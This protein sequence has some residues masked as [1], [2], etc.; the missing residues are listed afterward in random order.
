MAPHALSSMSR[1]LLKLAMR[2]ELEGGLRKEGFLLHALLGGAL[3]HGGVNALGRASHRSS[4]VADV[5]AHRAF[6][7]GAGGAG[8]APGAKRGLKLLLGPESMLQ[9]EAAEAAGRHFY[10][11]DP[12]ARGAAMRA[13]AIGVGALPAEA[14]QA[15]GHAPIL[16][17]LQ[18]AIQHDLAGTA[19]ELRTEGG[20]GGLASRVYGS[21]VGTLQRAQ[22]TPFSTPAQKATANVAGLLPAAALA[23]ADPAGGLTHMGWNTMREVLGRSRMGKRVQE[24]MLQRGLAGSIPSSAMEAVSDLALSPSFLDPQRVGH[25]VH[26]AGLVPAVTQATELVSKNK[27]LLQQLAQHPQVPEQAQGILSR[28]PGVAERVQGLLPAAG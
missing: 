19:P 14:Q 3:G 9:I 21:A 17:P 12:A 26:R 8:M 7:A 25:A 4:N 2:Q 28:L 5:L 1:H 20:L 27:E 16:G 10:G 15:L 22:V 24:S 23:A 18:R 11:M 13:A 6:Q